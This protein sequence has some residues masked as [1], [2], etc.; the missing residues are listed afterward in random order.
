MRKPKILFVS[1]EV[2]PFAKV[3]GLADVVGVLPG[4]LVKLGCDAR[5]VMPLYRQIKQ[6]YSEE[7]TFKRWTMLKLGW[8]SMYSG[9]FTLE[10]DGVTYY[11]IDNEYYFGHDY[12]YLDYSFD[13]ERF[14]FFQRA[15]LE[16]MGDG[17]Q[18]EPDVL[19][20]N[21]WQAAMIPVLLDA[22]YRPHGYH[23]NVKTVVTIHNLK[24][25][26]IH[27]VERIADLCD[28]APQYLTSYG[29]L[30][31]GVPNFLKA[32]I[33]YSDAITTVSPTYAQE[34]LTGYYGEGLDG[35]LRN[36]SYKLTGILNGLD[37][38][39]YNPET[40]PHIKAN[41]SVDTY[42]EGKAECKAE[43]QEI[44]NL[45]Q[46]PGAPLLGIITRLVDQKGIDLLTRVLDEMLFDG[47][48]V[49]ILGTGDPFY[50]NELRKMSGHRP[51]QLSININYSNDLAH[52]IYAG[53]DIFLMP[54]LF[55]PCGLSQMIAMRYG[56]VPIVRETGGLKDTVFPY[57]QFTGEG[58]GFSFS[59]I[60]AHELL[61]TAKYACDVYRNNKEAWK[62]LVETGMKGDYSWDTSAAKYLALYGNLFGQEW[63]P[64]M[65]DEE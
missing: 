2:A 51:E 22:H 13:I 41:Y 11:F 18:F 39:E 43:L 54:S 56:T 37:L 62:G 34:I 1:S 49:V 31:D 20:C 47:M 9:L 19:H 24:Y 36:Y 32:G 5:V 63:K 23:T 28:L 55:E 59:N 38:V 15:V 50:E 30:K 64:N 48:Q 17:M 21:D 46:N 3:G 44:L 8:R 65:F 7:L 4:E 16:A 12:I 52:K 6:K 10:K 45:E 29:V 25:Q 58:N 35:V 42:E 61:F 26:G 57:N 53:A 14:S 60:N 33:V 27:G 40:D